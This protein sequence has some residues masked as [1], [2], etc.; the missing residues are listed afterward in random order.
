MIVGRPNPIMDISGLM[1][2]GNI[3][4]KDGFIIFNNIIL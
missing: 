2:K 1:P 3:I 4:F